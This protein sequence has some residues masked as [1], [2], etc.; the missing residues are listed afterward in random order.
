MIL[1]LACFGLFFI[2][3]LALTLSVCR[4]I[5][6]AGKIEPPQEPE[7]RTA[8]YLYWRTHR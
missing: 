3:G 4:C 6:N 8:E 1:T 2:L 7:N 5:R